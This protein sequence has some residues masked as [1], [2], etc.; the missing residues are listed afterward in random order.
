VPFNARGGGTARDEFFFE[1]ELLRAGVRFGV[2]G[3]D[4]SCFAFGFLALTA[5]GLA[6]FFGD[7]P[8]PRRACFLE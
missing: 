5:L 1:P 2:L 3:E 7:R 6:G 4:F 8:A